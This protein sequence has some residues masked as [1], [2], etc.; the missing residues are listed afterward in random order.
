MN[1]QWGSRNIISQLTGP[2]NTGRLK[3]VVTIY[4]GHVPDLEV[5]TA[6]ITESA[7]LAQKSLTQ[8]HP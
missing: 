3:N 7:L 4:A 8:I 1:Y 6:L 2:V 5:V